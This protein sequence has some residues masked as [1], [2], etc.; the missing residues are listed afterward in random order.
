MKALEAQYRRKLREIAKKESTLKVTD[1]APPSFEARVRQGNQEKTAKMKAAEADYQVKLNEIAAKPSVLKLPD[2]PLPS[3]EERVRTNTEAR[4][5]K[6]FENHAA[7]KT[8]VQQRV[9]AQ[10]ERVGLAA[11]ARSASV[12]DLQART[13]AKRREQRAKD[14]HAVTSLLFGV[15]KGGLPRASSS[16][17]LGSSIP[18][19]EMERIMERFSD[20]IWNRSLKERAE[21]ERGYWRWQATLKASAQCAIDH[22]FL[23]PMGGQTDVQ[24]ELIAKAIAEK[25]YWKWAQTLKTSHACTIDQAWTSFGEEPEPEEPRRPDAASSSAGLAGAVVAETLRIP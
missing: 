15:P 20:P 21:A 19:K 24:R 2:N 16:P 17:R 1:K 3:F 22:Q 5:R 11:S 7:Y 10:G 4:A 9:A 8:W 23:G 12:A 18:A 14:S 13:A 25:E 6:D